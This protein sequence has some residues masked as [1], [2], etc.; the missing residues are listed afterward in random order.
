MSCQISKCLV[1][2]CKHNDSHSCQAESIEVRPVDDR[3]TTSST[4][5]SCNTFELKS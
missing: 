5:T 2:E 1:S 3:K 4:G